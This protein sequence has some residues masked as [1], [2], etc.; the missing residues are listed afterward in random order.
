M[1]GDLLARARAAGLSDRAIRH[2]D[3]KT[4]QLAAD[5]EAVAIELVAGGA[6]PGD[7]AVAIESTIPGVCAQLLVELVALA[8]LDD[9]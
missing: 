9:A 2:L 5:V 6:R 7:V 4:A 3:R 1:T 8:M